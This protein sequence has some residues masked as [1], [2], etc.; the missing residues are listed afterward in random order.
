MIATAPRPNTTGLKNL[1]PILQKISLGA[2]TSRDPG[3]IRLCEENR[4]VIIV[5]FRRDLQGHR[6]E[7]P[8]PARRM[9]LEVAPPG[10]QR[11]LSLLDGANRHSDVSQPRENL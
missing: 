3:E 5:R 11:R 6:K 9:I 10:P 7:S 2:S 4:R 8:P 1:P